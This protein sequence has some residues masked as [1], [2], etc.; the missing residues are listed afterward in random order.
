MKRNILFSVF[1]L[2]VVIFFSAGTRVEASTIEAS[3]NKGERVW[4]FYQK[5]QKLYPGYSYSQFRDKVMELNSRINSEADFHTIPAGTFL[6]FPA[7]TV[8]NNGWEAFGREVNVVAK[9]L[10]KPKKMIPVVW[11]R[12]ERLPPWAREITD[13]N[14]KKLNRRVVIVHCQFA[15]QENTCGTLAVITYVR[16]AF[17]VYASETGQRISSFSVRDDALFR[18]GWGQTHDRYVITAMFA[19]PK[20]WKKEK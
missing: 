19:K 17:L 8:E 5:W 14:D 16:H 18:E 2:V 10:F 15:E 7:P 20:T 9:R 6:I 4:T 3:L 1:V 13:R 11:S 12:S